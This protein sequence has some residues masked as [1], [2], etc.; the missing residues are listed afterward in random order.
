MTSNIKPNQEKAQLIALG[1]PSELATN[2]LNSRYKKSLPTLIEVH[3]YLISHFSHEELIKVAT[4]NGAV[5]IL[6]SIKN[7]YHL[8]HQWDFSKDDILEIIR[9]DGGAKNLEAVIA[10]YDALM[11]LGYSKVNI[12]KMVSHKGGSKNLEAV[13]A[14]HNALMEFG[15]SKEDLIKMVSHG[16]GSKNLEAVRANHDVLMKFGFSKENI[17]KMVSHGGGS[18]NLAAIEAN[19]EVLM[20]FGFGTEDLI[21]IVSHSGG[22]KNL[23]IVK[24]KREALIEFGFSKEDILKMVSHGGG[25]KN[26][27]SVITNYET[28]MDFGFNKGAILKMVSHHGGSKNLAAVKASREALME[29]GFSK[30][31][32]LKMVNHDGGSKNLAAINTNREVLMEFGLSKE[33]LLKMVN[34]DGG[35]KNLEAVKANREAL[36][37]FGFNNEDILKMVSHGGGSKNLEAVKASREALMEFGLSKE[38]ILKMVSH[39]GGSKNLEAIK[40]SREALMEFGFSKEDILKMVSHHGGSKNLEAVK[41]NREAL[42]GFGFSQ[43]DILKMVSHDGGSKNLEAVKANREALMEFG[44]GKED[45]IRILNCRS[46]GSGRLAIVL[47]HAEQ[48]KARGFTNQLIIEA[49]HHLGRSSLHPEVTVENIH[50][51]LTLSRQ[52]KRLR[53]DFF[54][55]FEAERMQQLACYRHPDSNKPFSAILDFSKTHSQGSTSQAFARLFAQY[56]N[57]AYATRKAEGTLEIDE[58][59]FRVENDAQVSISAYGS[60]YEFLE[61]E[62]VVLPFSANIEELPALPLRSHSIPPTERSF[63]DEWLE[64]ELMET[65]PLTRQDEA[66]E[67]N[68]LA[69]QLQQELGS[70]S[71]SQPTVMKRRRQATTED[72]QEPRPAKRQRRAN[73][74]TPLSSCLLDTLPQ[75]TQFQGL[76]FTL[77]LEVGLALQRRPQKEQQDM[78]IERVTKC[79]GK[80]LYTVKLADLEKYGRFLACFGRKEN[81][82]PLTV[83]TSETPFLTSPSLLTIPLNPTLPEPE[84]TEQRQGNQ[85]EEIDHLEEELFAVPA[86]LLPNEEKEVGRLSQLIQQEHPITFFQSGPKRQR[87]ETSSALTLEETTKLKTSG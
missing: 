83:P 10:N 67:I 44:F 47:K 37:E 33:N 62:D 76:K 41:V 40:T 36:M 55:H 84:C 54:R 66:P 65:P 60:F 64:Q 85:D 59:H 5:N 20:E 17:L 50:V 22:S 19:R 57:K 7:H 30:E 1:Y 31:D 4:Y 38:D 71:P 15:F 8:L 68:N 18:K 24:A 63:I 61:G 58:N 78:G 46:G 16:G 49:I 39:H 77:E 74:T 11:E 82:P 6:C 14:N 35:S 28:L 51:Q 42:M 53:K 87:V 13:K 56:M 86:P 79:R 45:L 48:L 52:F 34:H 75:P 2:Y 32:I 72:A 69:R 21:K 29:F 25:S 9:K 26:L 80:P 43:E 12:L 81:A 23:E 70:S 3:A 27:D 73:A